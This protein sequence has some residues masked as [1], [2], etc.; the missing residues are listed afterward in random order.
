MLTAKSATAITDM[1]PAVR[2]Q[3]PLRDVALE[4]SLTKLKFNSNTIVH[5]NFKQLNSLVFT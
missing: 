2:Q 3:D 5:K 1:M 4:I